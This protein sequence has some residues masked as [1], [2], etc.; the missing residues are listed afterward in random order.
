MKI[1][2]VAG[3]RP[4][5]VKAAPLLRALA[6]AK[7]RRPDLQT[8]FVD[9]GQHYDDALAGAFYRE[10]ELPEP[11]HELRIASGSHA[12]QTALAMQRFEPVVIAERP[13]TVVVLGDI[14]STLACAL[15][16]A[17]LGV[18]VAHVEAG[19]RSF[20]RR[21]PEEINR[22]ATDAVCDD[23]FTTEESANLN[24][25][26]EGVAAER[27]H[28]VGNLMVDS[29]DWIQPHSQ[30]SDVLVRLGLH[31]APTG[32]ALCTL[33]RPSNVDAPQQLRRLLEPLAELAEERPLLLA[34][35]PR[36]AARLA[37]LGAREQLVHMTPEA[38]N[39]WARGRVSILD[40]LRYRDFVRLL[41]EARLVLTDSGGVQEE[42][43]CLGVPCVTLRDNTERPVT[44]S[45]GTNVLGGTSREGILAAAAERLS[46]SRVAIRRPPLWDG[47]AAQRIV[48]TL[49]GRE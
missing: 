39:G 41:S 46:Q 42:A 26:R 49:V 24:L 5:F 33:H 43:T 23:L 28:F 31:A 3:A 36:T 1:L 47:C 18:R 32:Y 16:A 2:V 6:A 27:I 38:C 22:L 21:M 45:H 14:N 34:A 40:P 4:N 8:C 30:Q 17:K 10:L 25:Q 44:I 20:D 37:D 9:T 35:H 11:E 29:L 15:V 7:V 19:L 13:H 48:S 12:E